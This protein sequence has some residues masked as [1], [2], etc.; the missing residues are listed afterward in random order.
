MNLLLNLCK[1]Q[2]E[3]AV[4][5]NRHKLLDMTCFS[6][7]VRDSYSFEF[8]RYMHTDLSAVG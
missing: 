4:I 1:K 7:C 3:K 5:V 6:T 8:K 2:S